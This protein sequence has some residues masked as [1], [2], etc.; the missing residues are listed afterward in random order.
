MAGSYCNYC[1][2]RCFVYR[3]VI[4]GGETVWTGHMATCAQ[5]RA[6]DRQV[7]GVDST[8]AHN[9]TD[10]ATDDASSVAAP[11]RPPRPGCG[12]TR[13]DGRCV[14]ATRATTCAARSSTPPKPFTTSRHSE[15]G[16]PTRAAS[17]PAKPAPTRNGGRSLPTLGPHKSAMVRGWNGIM[18]M[19][20]RP[21]S[22]FIEQSLWSVTC[23]GGSF[24]PGSPGWRCS[25]ATVR[26]GG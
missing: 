4:V 5:G 15:T 22:H 6:H 9:P 18:G 8:Q 7:L 17:F 23:S 12:S 24:T 21:G 3:E 19:R 1:D 26:P 11:R 2:Q 16:S 10:A 14:T 20:A 13:A 25:G